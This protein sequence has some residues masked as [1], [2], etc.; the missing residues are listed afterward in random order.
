MAFNS[1]ESTL[2]LSGSSAMRFVDLELG[3]L[4][5]E[6]PIGDASDFHWI[7]DETILFGNRDGLWATVTL[8]PQQLAAETLSNLTRGFTPDECDRYAFDPCPETVDAVRERYSQV[9]S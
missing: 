7:D 3:E 1:D 8:D 9:G 4:I 2:V 5:R 6:L